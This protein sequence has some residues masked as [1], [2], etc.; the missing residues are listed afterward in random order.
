MVYCGEFFFYSGLFFFSGLY[1]SI[2]VYSSSNTTEQ[3]R[4]D[5]RQDAVMQQVF[6]VVNTL[7]R[8]DKESRRR[9]LHI[10]TYKV[11]LLEKVN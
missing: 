5:L 6:G 7:L 10:R 2:V 8:K 9:Q 11:S 4:D 3:G 1:S